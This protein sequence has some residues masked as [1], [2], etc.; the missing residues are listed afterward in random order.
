[1]TLSQ[2]SN[3]TM[4]IQN[5]QTQK[6]IWVQFFVNTQTKNVLIFNVITIY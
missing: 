1:M 5:I 6:W 2:F 4:K 3:V